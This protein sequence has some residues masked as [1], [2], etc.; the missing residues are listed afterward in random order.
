MILFLLH[1]ETRN[2]GMWSDV[3]QRSQ[4]V[5][6]RIML[7]SCV[8]LIQYQIIYIWH[9]S[10]KNWV[11]FSFSLLLNGVALLTYFLQTLPHFS[12]V[13]IAF[14]AKP[15]RIFLQILPHFSKVLN[16]RECTQQPIWDYQYCI[17]TQSLV[18]ECGSYDTEQFTC[19]WS[20]IVINTRRDVII[21]L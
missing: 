16:Y 17:S 2:V 15:C 5:Y 7:F 21:M 20:V 8:H 10:N 9:F 12:R 14:F 6:Y 4:C 19:L 11:Y 18:I 3:I 13:I 1:D